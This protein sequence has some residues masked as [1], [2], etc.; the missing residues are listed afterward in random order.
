MCQ[1]LIGTVQQHNHQYDGLEIECQFLIGTVQQQY[2]CGLNDTLFQNIVY[3]MPKS[4]S[5]Y[6]PGHDSVNLPAEIKG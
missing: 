1:F 5:I 3:N 6:F 4:R 2:L